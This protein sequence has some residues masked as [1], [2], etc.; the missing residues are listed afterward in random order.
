MS[1]FAV[2][3]PT[4]EDAYWRQ[5]FRDEPYYRAPLSYDDYSPAYRVGYT[6]PLRREG[7]FESLEIVLRNDWEQVKGRSRIDWAQARPAIRAAWDRA[8]QQCE[9]TA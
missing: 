4:A 2:I 7:S 5:A 6:G 8:M 3:N 1:F 9:A